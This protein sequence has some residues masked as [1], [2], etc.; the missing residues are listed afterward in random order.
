MEGERCLSQRCESG[1]AS[2]GGR[3]MAVGS[4]FQLA[5]I[6][7]EGNEVVGEES[8]EPSDSGFNAAE[9]RASILLSSCHHMAIKTPRTATKGASSFQ[10]MLH[11]YSDMAPLSMCQCRCFL[12]SVFCLDRNQKVMGFQRVALLG[13]FAV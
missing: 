9:F 4:A 12:A 1:G 11:A 3:R 13:A 10:L 7:V 8:F 6:P 5:D 2:V